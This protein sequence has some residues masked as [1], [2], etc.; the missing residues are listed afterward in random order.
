MLHWHVFIGFYPFFASFHRISQQISLLS[1]FFLDAPLRPLLVNCRFTQQQRNLT[2][3]IGQ[4]SARTMASCELKAMNFGVTCC[5]WV[6]GASVVLLWYTIT[7]I[8]W[9][10]CFNISVTSGKIFWRSM[11]TVL[12]VY[13]LIYGFTTDAIISE[14]FQLVTSC[15]FAKKPPLALLLSR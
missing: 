10:I 5:W 6:V 12:Y 15:T 13:Y 3:A 14:H 11:F 8:I 7:I 4:G 9:I 2:I 1:S